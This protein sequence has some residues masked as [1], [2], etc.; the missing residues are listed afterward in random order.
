MYQITIKVLRH[1]ED[2]KQVPHSNL[3][4]IFNKAIAEM[5][6]YSHAYCSN[7]SFDSITFTKVES[8][9]TTM[10]KNILA[11]GITVEAKEVSNG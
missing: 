10:F 5:N 3:K 7:N 8:N 11:E 2:G 9:L 4:S 1:E 6:R